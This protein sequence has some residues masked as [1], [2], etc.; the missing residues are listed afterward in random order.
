MTERD[1]RRCRRAADDGPYCG[2]CAADI[3][4]KA[5]N[6]LYRGRRKKSSRPE[7]PQPSNPSPQLPRACTGSLLLQS[8]CRPI[9]PVEDFGLK[10]GCYAD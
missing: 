2:T 5:L 8:G 1:C 7:P 6:P 10:W 3:M 4:A 9:A